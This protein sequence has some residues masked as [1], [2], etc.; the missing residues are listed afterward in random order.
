MSPLYEKLRHSLRDIAAP[1]AQQQRALEALGVVPDE[2]A[3]ELDGYGLA[4]K[5]LVDSGELSKSA[6]EA[7]LDLLAFF[8]TFGGAE[9]ASEWTM[10][11]L[12]SSPNWARARDK[13][14][15][16]LALMEAP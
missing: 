11:A 5:S 8:D 14:A 16:A 1:A 6:H 9:N 15:K 3:L 2:L 4:A 13:A 7:V 12:Y 10:D